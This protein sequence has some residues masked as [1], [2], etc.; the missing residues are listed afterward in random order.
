LSARR[1]GFAVRACRLA[2]GYARDEMG[3]GTATVRVKESN[4]ASVRVAQALGAHRVGEETAE[5]GTTMVVL[6][7]DLREA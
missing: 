5:T 3:R 4:V 6:E 1:R 2:L 7:L